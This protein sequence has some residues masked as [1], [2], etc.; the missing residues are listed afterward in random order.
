MKKVLALFVIVMG[1]LFLVPFGWAWHMWE[2]SGDARWWMTII[3][4][5]IMGSLLVG[6]GFLIRQAARN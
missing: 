4:A 2:A 1:L 6:L 3:G 5:P